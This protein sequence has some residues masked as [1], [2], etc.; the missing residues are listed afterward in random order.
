MVSP[1]R[2]TDFILPAWQACVGMRFAAWAV[3]G[4]CIHRRD[5]DATT[6]AF[7][8]RAGRLRATRRGIQGETGVSHSM[9]AAGYWRS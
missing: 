5:A 9:V 2:W 8:L 1:L 4:I 3:S 7:P 6:S